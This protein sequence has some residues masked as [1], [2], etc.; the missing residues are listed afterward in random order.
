MEFLLNASRIPKF[1][2]EC[3]QQ[4]KEIGSKI[5]AE[6][7]DV[8]GDLSWK[9]AEIQHSYG[10]GLILLTKMLKG[11]DAEMWRT[12]AYIFI[13]YLSYQQWGGK[14]DSIVSKEV[15]SS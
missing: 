11:A 1:F 14:I 7:G 6:Y 9:G 3:N 15:I 12:R 8:K 2:D 4:A 5:W 10:K 13:Q